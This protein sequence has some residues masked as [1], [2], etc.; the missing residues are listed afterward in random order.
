MADQV[1]LE[2]AVQRHIVPEGGM[3]TRWV[4]IAEWMDADGH[5]D[6]IAENATDMEQW[7]VD[8]LLQYALN[9]VDWEDVE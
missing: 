4:V 6:L 3:L 2:D 1:T 8:G 9:N 5:K 7:D